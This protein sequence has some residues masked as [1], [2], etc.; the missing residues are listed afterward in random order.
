LNWSIV[1][2]EDAKRIPWQPLRFQTA[3]HGWDQPISAE[4][5]RSLR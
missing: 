3:Q 5:A 4:G 1:N 2:D